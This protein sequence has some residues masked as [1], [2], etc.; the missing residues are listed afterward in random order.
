MGIKNNKNTGTVL[1]WEYSYYENFFACPKLFT[2][3]AEA[4][5]E[6]I[7]ISLCGIIW[8]IVTQNVTKIGI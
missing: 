5:A 4:N 3:L 7:G 8:L 1:D 2:P 6:L